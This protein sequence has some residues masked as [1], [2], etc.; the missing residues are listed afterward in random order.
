M[1]V[2]D[3]PYPLVLV[4]PEGGKNLLCAVDEQHLLFL[5]GYIEVQRPHLTRI[6]VDEPAHPCRVV[7]IGHPALSVFHRVEYGKAGAGNVFPNPDAFVSGICDGTNGTISSWQERAFD[8]YPCVY[9]NGSPVADPNGVDPC[10][11]TNRTP[12]PWRAVTEHWSAYFNLTWDISDTFQLTLE[13]R[14]VDET[15]EILRPNTSSCTNLFFAFG[16]EA[17]YEATGARAGLPEIS[18]C[19]ETF[20]VLR[21]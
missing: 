17:S 7:E 6:H 9:D 21:G 20:P 11:R 10:L 14:Y 12:A 8:I 15:F 13:N 16:Y 3:L 5:L 1:E 2:P 4:T 18:P 19:T